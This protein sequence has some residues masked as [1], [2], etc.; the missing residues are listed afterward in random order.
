MMAV[1]SRDEAIEIAVS[2][3]GGIAD[4]LEATPL[5]FAGDQAI[6]E[7]SWPFPVD[8]IQGYW[9][10]E[11]TRCH[12]IQILADVAAMKFQYKQIHLE[13]RFKHLNQLLLAADEKFRAFVE[14]NPEMFADAFA[15]QDTDLDGFLTY[16]SNGFEYDKTGIEL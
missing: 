3:L 10:I 15:T 2:L 8:G 12:I 11:R 4:N 6:S 5:E 1:G 7:T 14:E 9:I 16:I 13:H